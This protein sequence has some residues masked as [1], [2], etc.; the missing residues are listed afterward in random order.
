MTAVGRA[1]AQHDPNL[2]R[3]STGWLMHYHFVAP[4]HL[5]PL[6]WGHLVLNVL[7]SGTV[8]TSET[9]AAEIDAFVREREHQELADRT[10]RSSASVFLATYSSPVGLGNLGLLSTTGGTAN[11]FA[12][13]V[14]VEVPWQVVAYV[15]ADFWEGV[16]GDRNQVPYSDIMAA[17]GPAAL[18]LLDS[19]T[20]GMHLTRMRQEHLIEVHRV[21]R[22]WTVARNWKSKDTLLEAVYADAD[23]D[24]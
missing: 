1:I 14:P 8:L 20:M 16:W 10:L 13:G 17:D 9:L 24:A 2:S 21:A 11:T 19:G 3:I 6:Y 15:L 4:H 5:G 18:L 22:P 7:R 12:V 23:T